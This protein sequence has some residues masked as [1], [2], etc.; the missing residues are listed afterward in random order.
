MSLNYAFGF[1]L[2]LLVLVGLNIYFFYT[3]NGVGKNNSNFHVPRIKLD[4]T[5]NVFEDIYDYLN[6]LPSQYKVKN[7]KFV[8]YQK[9]LLRSFN[10]T[11][12]VNTT[13]VWRETEK[14]NSEVSL[15]PHEDT[16]PG[17]IL[18]AIQTA[19]IA[20]VDN[21][22]KGTQLKLILL[23]E[24]KQKLFFKPKRYS[25]DYV[26]NGNIYGGFDRHN[27]EV[28]AYYLAM[29]LNMKWIAPS[30]IRRIHLNKDILPVATVGLKR[31]M[32][33]NESGLLCIFGKCFYCKRN[34]TVCPDQNGHI[35][36]AAILYLDKQFK[37]H[38]SPWRRSY[39][40]RSMEWQNDKDFCKKVKGLL[41]VKR[42]LNL[43]DVAIFDFLIQNG[44]RH[45]YEV[46]KDQIVLL[47]NGKGLGNPRV[48]ELDILA[49]L[50]Q[51]CMLASSTWQ[52]LEMVSGGSLTETIKLLAALHGHQLAREEHFKAVERR[53]MK[54][55]ATIQYCI[56][57]HGRAKVIQ[58][59]V[60]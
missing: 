38:K 13:S 7:S 57:K 59:V 19:P 21:A 33:K 18:H 37:V 56:G 9:N 36:G 24:G 51:C 47:D 40:T 34:E 32:I 41:S 54:V 55:Y 22:P 25:L 2:F 3:L 8:P 49:P 58:N 30:A 20:L 28:F 44:D 10:S 15:F 12:N 31:S 39:T 43:V 48:D 26:I 6:Y 52:S 4:L 50:Y 5:P 14:W 46:Y 35:E 23:L 1:S 60:L 17:K 53:L 45:H 11:K 42:I 27:S 16:T 29:V